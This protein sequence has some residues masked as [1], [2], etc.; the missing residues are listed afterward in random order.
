MLL[1][2]DMVLNVDHIRKF[3]EKLGPDVTFAE[4]P[5]AIHDVFL[6]RK[7]VREQAFHELFSWLEKE[8]RH[9]AVCSS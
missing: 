4:I 8:N 7:E 9:A 2:T 6:S 5:G 1:K 3:G